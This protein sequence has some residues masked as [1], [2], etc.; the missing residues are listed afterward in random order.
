MHSTSK[1]LGW[2]KTMT[3]YQKK[4][5]NSQLHWCIHTPDRIWVSNHKKCPVLQAVSQ[6]I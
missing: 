6:L 4:D 3:I 1:I 5:Y 2:E